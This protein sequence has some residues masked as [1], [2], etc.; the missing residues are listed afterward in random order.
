MST[1]SAIPSFPRSSGISVR[2]VN[3]ASPPFLS[4]SKGMFSTPRNCPAIACAQPVQTLPLA[5]I[6]FQPL[7]CVGGQVTVE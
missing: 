6:G 7:V 5:Q 4:S 3:V 1:P 2:T